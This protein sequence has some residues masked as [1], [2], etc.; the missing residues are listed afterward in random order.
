MNLY[1]DILKSSIGDLYII[2]N[3]NKVVSIDIGKENFDENCKVYIKKYGREL[4]QDEKKLESII[5]QLKDY[6]EGKT[7]KFS[8]DF[9]LSGTE[10][11]KAVYNAML[12]IPYGEVRTYS[13][14]AKAINNEKAVRAIGQACKSNSIPVIV[15]CHRVV[16]KNN[17]LGGYMG[18][19]TN[20]KEILIS[21]E[22]SVTN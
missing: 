14:I 19:H 6:F 22:K 3:N 10:F 9:E 5:T 1:Y 11:Q 8:I 4:M 2:V 7:K 15:P 13:D 21:L 18:S 20:L 16:S 17:K 12:E